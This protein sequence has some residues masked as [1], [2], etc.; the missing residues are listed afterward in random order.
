MASSSAGS[1][2]VVSTN[3][4]MEFTVYNRLVLDEFT[5]TLMLMLGP[6]AYFKVQGFGKVGGAPLLSKVD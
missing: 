1:S 2:A 6:G 4:S 3:T 5:F